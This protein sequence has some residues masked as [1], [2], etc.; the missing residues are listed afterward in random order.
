MYRAAPLF[1][2]HSTS[3]FATLT[4]HSS[5][6]LYFNGI[7]CCRFLHIRTIQPSLSLV[8]GATASFR[9]VSPTA[10]FVIHRC[11]VLPPRL[12][13]TVRPSRLRVYCPV[14]SFRRQFHSLV[15][16]CSITSAFASVDPSASFTTAQ[17][18]GRFILSPTPVSHS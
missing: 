13:F 6:P 3:S 14:A 18:H 16:I 17:F 12:P 10:C 9:S 7:R 4:S 11:T 5:F 15:L 8:D 1:G 2:V